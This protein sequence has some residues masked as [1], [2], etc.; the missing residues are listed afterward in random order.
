ME[1]DFSVSQHCNTRL[2]YQYNVMSNTLAHS[3]M[4]EPIDVHQETPDN[5]SESSHDEKF[6]IPIGQSIARRQIH[7]VR[8]YTSEKERMQDEL[9]AQDNLELLK[10]YKMFLR[11]GRVDDTATVFEFGFDTKSKALEDRSFCLTSLTASKTLFDHLTFKKLVE[12][13]LQEKQCVPILD[14][15]GKVT[16][17][18]FTPEGAIHKMTAMDAG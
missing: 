7:P 2:L 16:S 5:A 17:R 18:C 8:E 12:P 10:D 13:P 14:A 3:S 9:A 1:D 11:A 6:Q 15:D 4:I